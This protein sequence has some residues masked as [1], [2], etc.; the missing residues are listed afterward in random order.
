MLQLWRLNRN[1]VER[2]EIYLDQKPSLGGKR[3]HLPTSSIWGISFCQQFPEPRY[4]GGVPE[5]QR[6]QTGTEPGRC[7]VQ[8]YP[9]SARGRSSPELMKTFKC[10]NRHWM[11]FDDNQTL[12]LELCLTYQT[13]EIMTRYFVRT[14][15][16]KIALNPLFW[17]CCSADTWKVNSLV[18]VTKIWVLIKK[19]NSL[20]YPFYGLDSKFQSLFLYD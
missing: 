5:F 19:K 13:K 9:H 18:I 8:T 17:T 20:H 4:R 1:I 7:S 6:S 3:V 14:F 15:E 11:S 10:A 2:R 12:N 16:V